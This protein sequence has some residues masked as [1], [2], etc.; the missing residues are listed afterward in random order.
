MAPL[1]R[2]SVATLEPYLPSSGTS[3]VSRR[4]P[5]GSRIGNSVSEFS[6]VEVLPGVFESNSYEKFLTIELD[7]E[8]KIEDLD[9][10]DVHDEIIKCCGREPK[11]AFQTGGSLL[12]E[13]VSPEE[14]KKLQSLRSLSGLTAKCSPHASF[15]QVRGVIHSK[16]L[17]RYS[18]E[19]IQEKLKNQKVVKVQRMYKTVDG[20]LVPLPTL[21][22]TFD[23]LTLPSVVKAAWLRFPV[24]PYVPTPKRCYHCQR[25]GHV[26][27]KCRLRLKNL[28]GTCFNCGQTAHGACDKI[29]FCINCGESHPSSSRNCERYV[30]ERE[31][32]TVRAKEHIS[33]SEAK[34]KVLSLCI[35][36]G[37]TF[38][39]VISKCKKQIQERKQHPIH[40][41]PEKSDKTSPLVFT[42]NNS[43][44]RNPEGNSNITV[45]V[46]KR[47][48][49]SDSIVAP[50]SKVQHAES[51]SLSSTKFC[52]EGMDDLPSLSCSV[53][54]DGVPS[55]AS[56]EELV[57]AVALADAGESAEVTPL[58]CSSGQAKDP[59]PTHSKW[60]DVAKKEKPKHLSVPPCNKNQLHGVSIAT[61]VLTGKKKSPQHS[62][63]GVSSNS[64]KIL[65]ES[66]RGRTIGKVL[67]NTSS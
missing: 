21:I 23:L 39:S 28:P 66:V 31:I 47:R 50:S 3:G 1:S 32:Q 12:I 4:K 9:I 54:R 49:S 10:F 22:L 29:P 27:D 37:V 41:V 7:G 63:S 65:N 59:S 16:D 5:S 56:S 52:V 36:P 43:T 13:T 58:A 45:S 53:G 48:H 46:G 20:N 60:V 8:R 2:S 24:R 61:R 57:G 14:S 34:Q 38:S 67:P 44:E 30:L 6:R 15:N 40:A 18:E 42:N 62:N 11:I 64:K 51:S 33:F 25:F 19:R 55:P 35:R 17:L 26:S